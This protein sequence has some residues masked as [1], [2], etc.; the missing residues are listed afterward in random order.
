MEEKDRRKE[1]QQKES[2]C[3]TWIVKDEKM[4]EH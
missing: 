3:S 2:E 1:E 4:L